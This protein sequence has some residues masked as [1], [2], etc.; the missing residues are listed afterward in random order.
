MATTSD[1]K[2]GVTFIFRD[3]IHEIVDVQHVMPARGAALFRTKL[4]NLETGKIYDN[5]FRSGEK[6]DLIELESRK[7]QFLYRDLGDY[8]LMDLD[9]FEQTHVR[10]ELFKGKEVYL[11]EGMEVS[12]ASAG[13]KLLE[14]ILPHTVDLVI[15]RTD[16]GV[17]GNTVQGSTKPATLETGAVVQVP[18]F[19]EQGTTVKV[20]TR[21]GIY[22]ERTY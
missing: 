2:S 14:V 8:V 5:T 3:H 21:T 4:R 1:F 17:T 13:D 19:V 9:T 22:L 16:P 6:I 10:E 20:D 15:T 12:V 11:K 7:M 18:L